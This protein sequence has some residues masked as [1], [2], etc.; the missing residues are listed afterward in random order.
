MNTI[1]DMDPI[2]Y[3]HAFAHSV[4]PLNAVIFLGLYYCYDYRFSIS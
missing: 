2:I 3:L 1:T 4:Q